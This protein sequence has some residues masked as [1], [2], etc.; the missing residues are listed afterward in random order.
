MALANGTSRIRTGPITLHTRTA[1]HVAEQLTNVSLQ[2]T[3]LDFHLD[4]FDWKNL[5]HLRTFSILFSRLK[6]KFVIHKAEDEQANNG[7]YIIEC[8]GVGATNSSL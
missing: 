2:S 1:I 5:G 8:Q 7:T 3:D 6:A 4:T